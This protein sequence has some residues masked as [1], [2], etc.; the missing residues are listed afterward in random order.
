M[1]PEGEWR[2]DSPMSSFRHDE[3]LLRGSRVFL[4]V[5]VQLEISAA[6]VTRT[7]AHKGERCENW[8]LASE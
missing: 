3:T 8:R 1:L 6:A 5:R 7:G 2:R 4:L